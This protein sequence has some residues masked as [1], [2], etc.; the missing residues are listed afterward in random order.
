MRRQL[1]LVVPLALMFAAGCANLH[2]NEPVD[3]SAGLIADQAYIY[4]RFDEIKGALNMSSLWIRLEN[5]GSGDN[6][7]IQVEDG[8]RVF[9]LE[10]GTY[11]MTEFLI[12]AGGAPKSM[13]T[14][15]DVQS[16]PIVP[17]QEPFRV[18]A[19]HAYYLGDFVAHADNKLVYTEN[20][21]HSRRDTFAETT[22]DVKRSYPSL[23]DLEFEISTGVGPEIETAPLAESTS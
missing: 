6:L 11:R 3:P 20:T 2:I 19:G 4:G 7:E 23:T 1:P 14:F 22:A 18:E 21:L 16:T 5:V 8:V 13:L 15:M 17:V 10:P 12:V 9:A